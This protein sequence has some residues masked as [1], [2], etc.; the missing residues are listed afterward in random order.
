IYPSVNISGNVHIGSVSEIGTGSNVIQHMKIG[1]NT[2]V[3]AGSV[4][5]KD[6]PANCTAVG[7]PAKAIKFHN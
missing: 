3:G 5:V 7:A 6:I 1:E 2:I 4:V